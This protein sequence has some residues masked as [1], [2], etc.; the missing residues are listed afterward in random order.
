MI[1]KSIH[2]N[3]IIIINIYMPYNITP[4]YIKQNLTELKKE[5]I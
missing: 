1:K 2:Q 4:K 5:A 3:N